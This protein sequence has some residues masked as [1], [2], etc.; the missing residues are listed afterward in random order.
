MAG[1]WYA[2]IAARA[3]ER[4]FDAATDTEMRI[5]FYM[6]FEH[7]EDPADQARAV[8]LLTERLSSDPDMALHARTD[9]EGVDIA[10]FE[11]A[12]HRLRNG[13]NNCQPQATSPRGGW[14]RQADR[15]CPQPSPPGGAGRGPI[16]IEESMARHW[17]RVEVYIQ[18]F[19]ITSL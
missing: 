10:E 8:E 14:S 1:T 11:R 9:A 12:A 18:A 2:L 6:P 7:S 16:W 15:L 19:R 13:V 17:E 3:I 5:F 4:Q